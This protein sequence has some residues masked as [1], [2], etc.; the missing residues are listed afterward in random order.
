MLPRIHPF[1]QYAEHD[2]AL[3]LHQVKQNMALVGESPG[4]AFEILPKGANRQLCQELACQ[5]LQA[6][7]VAIGLV[8]PPLFHCALDDPCE[9][10][11]CSLGLITCRRAGAET[12][13]AWNLHYR[14]VA[15]RER[16]EDVIVLSVGDP[17]LDRPAPVV[18]GAVAALQG[19]DTH[20]AEVEGRQRLRELI[21]A[22]HCG[23]PA[24]ADNVIVL[25]GA[26]NALLATAFG[27][28][29]AGHIRLAY[30][31]DEEQLAE[32]GRR[33]CDFVAGLS[34]SGAW[35]VPDTN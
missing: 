34:A 1:V 26:Q 12:V 35:E 15:A 19:G 23:Q 29:A 21:A 24:G 11:F 8:C 22:Q 3:G 28:C 25:A 31:V 18:E 14:G 33:I 20:Y 5:A 4:G 9:V 10:G 6:I 16:G 13:D 2:Q 7:N 27:A 30:T 32:A 17:D